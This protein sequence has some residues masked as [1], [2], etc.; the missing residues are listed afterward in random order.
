[1]VSHDVVYE[2]RRTFRVVEFAGVG[3]KRPMYKII[4]ADNQEYGPITIEQMRQW[5]AEGRVNAQ[6]LVWSETSN[7]WKPLSAY[8]EFAVAT[9]PGTQPPTGVPV[10]D[11][12]AALN[13]VSG[14]A[15]GLVIA[16]ILGIIVSL[17]GIAMNALG[18]GMQGLNG[19]PEAQKFSGLIAGFGIVGGIIKIIG[20]A[21]VVYGGIKMKK[22]ENYGLCMTANIIAMIPCVSGCCL[23]G[24]PVG[25]FGLIALNAPAVKA[26]F[27]Q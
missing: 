23:V 4:G 25:I 21:V 5:L 11:P 16:G 17:I 24:L 22:L 6:T 2:T 14:P 18:V 9:P 20:S 13:K 3:H 7:N 27:K 8:P 10:A 15:T 19:I 1:M 26:A 12:N